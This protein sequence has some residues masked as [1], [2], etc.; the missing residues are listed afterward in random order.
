MTPSSLTAKIYTALIYSALL[1]RFYAPLCL[2]PLLGIATYLSFTLISP[3]LSSLYGIAILICLVSIATFISVR[4]RPDSIKPTL[5][6][7]RRRL[8]NDSHLPHQPLTTLHD[9]P[10]NPEHKDLWQQHQL[11]ARQALSHVRYRLRIPSLGLTASDPYRLRYIVLILLIITPFANNSDAKPQATI[12][13]PPLSAIWIT[14]P[15]Y[16][17]Q[18]KPTI[19]L[20]DKTIAAT[21]QTLIVA[22]QSVLRIQQAPNAQNPYAIINTETLPLKRNSSQQWTSTHT[23][24][25]NSRLQFCPQQDRT[26]CLDAVWTITIK[27]DLPPEVYVQNPIVDHHHIKIASALIDD[28]AI[29]DQTMTMALSRPVSG[30]IATIH[31]MPPLPPLSIPAFSTKESEQPITSVWQ[32]D[33]THHPLSQQAVQFTLQATDSA[34]Q[35]TQRTTSSINLPARSFTNPIA[36]QIIT[37]REKLFFLHQSL[38]TA[39]MTLRKL[40]EGLDKHSEAYQDISQALQAF[41]SH[42]GNLDALLFSADQLWQAA[43][44]LEDPSGLEKALYRLHQAIDAQSLAKTEEQRQAAEQQLQEALQQYQH[45]DQQADSLNPNDPEQMR[46]MLEQQQD[47]R[48]AQQ[49]QEYIEKLDKIKERQENI[50]AET[51]SAETQRAETQNAETQD[52][53]PQRDNPLAEQQQ[54]LAQDW[55][56]PPATDSENLS[57]YLEGQKHMQRSA[58]ALTENAPESALQEQQQ[59]LQALNNL[60]QALQDK[61]QRNAAQKDGMRFD[62]LGRPLI[63][64]PYDPRV[65]VPADAAQTAVGRV[66]EKLKKRMR[67]PSLAQEE[68]TYLERLLETP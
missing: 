3:T 24:R 41:P 64:N 15:D 48:L 27:K 40:N 67:D 18:S 57:L 11:S 54:D 38:L 51:Q 61:Q 30:H 31:Q 32:K 49:Q 52:T 68:K 26:T 56:Q 28:D 58:D 39:E 8:E 14:S 20:M 47:Q 5:A 37:E 7:A 43:L 6:T 19:I 35:K 29:I 50:R 36:K 17:Y 42:H 16:L 55:Q 33:L 34:Q 10:I 46:Q 44:I 2:Y 45:Y 4:K 22:E 62:P 9:T 25:E 65:T 12:T 13:Q 60:Q 23:L 66:A 59:A 21:S 1:L 53:Q 63:I